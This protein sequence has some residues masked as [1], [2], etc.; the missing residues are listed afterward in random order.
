MSNVTSASPRISVIVATYNCVDTLAQCLDSICS[1][2]FSPVELIVIDGGSTD[3][4][5]ELLQQRSSQI[6]YLVSEPDHGIYDA[7]NK[8]LAHA[9]GEWICFLG[10]DDYFWNADVLL[11]SAQQL[12][13]LPAETLIAYGKIM[14][15]DKAGKQLYASGQPWADVGSRFRALMSIP[16][17]G[18]MHRAE[19]FKRHGKF[20]PSF[21]IAGDY[22]LLLRELK[23][24]Q[25]YFLQ[26]MVTAGVRHGGVSTDS[27]NILLAMHEIRRAQKKQNIIIPPLLWVITI[28]KVYLRIAL[29]N[30]VG[31]SISERLLNL[32][33]KC[34][35]VSFNWTETKSQP[36][37]SK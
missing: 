4:T 7:W 34:P 11:L 26:D 19:L 28:S 24:G 6:A 12:L 21:R 15:V 23:N 35:G 36:D 10:A 18:T 30:I 14:V 3:G 25:A 29:L 17:P 27:K 20:D 2:T 1:Q 9:S 33:R 8:G 16:H 5:K 22:D 31:K 32:V 37:E 13:A